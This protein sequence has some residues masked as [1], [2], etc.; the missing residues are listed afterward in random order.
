MAL[1]ALGEAE[2]HGYQLAKEMEALGGTRRL[3]SHGTLYKALDRL[4]AAGLVTDRWEDPAIAA[5]ANRP[6]RRLYEVTARGSAV[7]A[8]IESGRAAP[9]QALRTRESTG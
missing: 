1:H 8:S 5:L 4:E 6:R 3:V 7:L 2:F 9:I